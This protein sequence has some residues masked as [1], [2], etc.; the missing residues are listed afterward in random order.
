MSSAQDVYNTLMQIDKLLADI[1]LK[2]DKLSSGGGGGGGASVMSVRRE[3]HIV[4]M[5][6]ISLERWSGNDTLAGIVNRIQ[7]A[8]Q[9][10]L[11]FQML[12]NAIIALE[13]VANAGAGPL[14]WLNLGAQGLGFAISA[15]NMYVTWSQ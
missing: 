2:I 10:A 8:A 14:G 12:L 11:R 3:L 9:L 7:S 15:Q 5:Y 4:N 13:A 6:L 1:E